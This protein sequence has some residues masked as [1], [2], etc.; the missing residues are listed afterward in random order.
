[1]IVESKWMLVLIVWLYKYMQVHV[2]DPQV[3]LPLS[4]PVQFLGSSALCR[5]MIQ[6]FSI[7]VVSGGVCVV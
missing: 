2:G 5:P 1:M 3:Y 7:L 4:F 6:S